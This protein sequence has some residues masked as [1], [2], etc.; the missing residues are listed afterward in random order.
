MV[1]DGEIGT[2]ILSLTLTEQLVWKRPANVCLHID[3]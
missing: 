1:R 2:I 3:V